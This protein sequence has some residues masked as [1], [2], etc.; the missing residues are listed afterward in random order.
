M[1]AA[2]LCLV[3]PLLPVLMGQFWGDLTPQQRS[4]GCKIPANV[5]KM[6]SWM[7]AELLAAAGAGR[8]SSTPANLRG[9]S[10]WELIPI[11]LLS[12]CAVPPWQVVAV[13]PDLGENGTVVYSIRPPNKFYSLNSTTGKIRT[14]GVLLDRE[15]PNAQ[16]AQLMRRIVVSVTDCKLPSHTD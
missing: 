8:P 7:E 15:N 1:I 4:Q 16:E 2:C 11:T 9:D 5:M 3:V 10:P 14:S 13:D 6:Q 12:F